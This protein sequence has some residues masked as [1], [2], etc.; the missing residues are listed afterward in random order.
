MELGFKPSHCDNRVHIHPYYS[1]FH[2]ILYFSQWHKNSLPLKKKNFPLSR[3]WASF[4]GMLLHAL[5]T[6]ILHWSQLKPDFLW[7]TPFLWSFLNQ[8]LLIIQHST[9]FYTHIFF[10]NKV[11]LLWN[12]CHLTESCSNPTH[13]CHL[14]AS[15]WGTNI[16]QPFGMRITICAV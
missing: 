10:K 11:L 16:P 5:H 13:Y 9:Y 15:S 4:S 14:Q 2:T 8:S 12:S 1:S 6:Q 3:L 7:R